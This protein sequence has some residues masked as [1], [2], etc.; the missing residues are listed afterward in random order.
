[1]FCISEFLAEVSEEDPELDPRSELF[2]REDDFSRSKEKLS[3]SEEF[4]FEL[5]GKEGA[6]PVSAEP[7][8]F[9]GD[10]VLENS[11]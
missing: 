10:G 9:F 7:T 11:N 4:E 2:I 8:E 5:E 3:D 1:M 6:D